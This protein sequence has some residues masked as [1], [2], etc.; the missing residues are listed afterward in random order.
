[1]V[2]AQLVRALDC[3][4]RSRG[5]ESRLPPNIIER[6]TQFILRD[7]FMSKPLIFYIVLHPAIVLQAHINPFTNANI[8]TMA[9]SINRIVLKLNLGNLCCVMIWKSFLEGL[10][11]FDINVWGRGNVF[12]IEFL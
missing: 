9:K 4:S 6:I 10:D 2:V 8:I 12:S 7:F 11:F 5:F 1:M 3:G